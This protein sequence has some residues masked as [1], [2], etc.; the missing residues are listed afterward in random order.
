MDTLEFLKRVLPS[1]GLYCSFTVVGKYPKQCHHQ[2]IEE[3]ASE[4]LT[5]SQKGHNTYYAISA[6]KSDE[7]REQVN[8]RVIKTFALDIDCGEGKPYS[9]WKEGI[10]VLSDYIRELNLPAPMIVRSGNGLHVYWILDEAIEPTQ[11][12]PLA[13]ALKAACLEKGFTPDIGVTGDS[14]RILRPIGCVNP[15]GGRTAT[16]VRDA[17][18]VTYAQLWAVLE[19]FTH[20]SSYEPPTEQ[21]RT[22]SLL[23]NLAVKHEYQPANAD[24]VAEG[25]QQIK[26]A[27]ENQGD[28]P[29]P[30][31]NLFEYSLVIS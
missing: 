27:I 4:V 12:K 22:N 28:V 5:D 14:A 6:F 20:G 7:S 15:K 2:T 24:K 3:L 17:Q 1:E 8:V 10:L 9:S 18:D 23:D 26:W 31:R 25:C 30:I 21:P 16:L 13:N 11:W 19:P 29:E